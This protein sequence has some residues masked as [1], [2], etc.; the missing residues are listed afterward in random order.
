MPE[1]A[2]SREV[3][4][5]VLGGVVCRALMSFCCHNEV[6]KSCW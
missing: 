1:I 2:A 5:R 4:E 3:L 6:Q